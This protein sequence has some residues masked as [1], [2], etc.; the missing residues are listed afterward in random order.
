VG[1]PPSIAGEQVSYAPAI[2][3]Y[4]RRIYPCAPGVILQPATMYHMR[5]GLIAS[6]YY[7]WINIYIAVYTQ[8]ELD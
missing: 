5:Q 3:H 2:T 1:P 4:R 8:C 6:S 7:P